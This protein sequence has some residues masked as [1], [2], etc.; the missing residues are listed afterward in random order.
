M[1]NLPQVEFLYILCIDI[2]SFNH[3]HM[4]YKEEHVL[5]YTLG[6]CISWIQAHVQFETYETVTH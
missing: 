1:D 3:V 4:A 6:Y 2:V 5:A